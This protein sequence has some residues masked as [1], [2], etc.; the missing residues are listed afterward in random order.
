MI[1]IPCGVN[2]DS[3]AAVSPQPMLVLPLAVPLLI[4]AAAYCGAGG[5]QALALEGAVSILLL[6]GAPFVAGAAIRAAR[7]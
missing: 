3:M 6:A 1:A 5:S 4:F 2:P 7:T